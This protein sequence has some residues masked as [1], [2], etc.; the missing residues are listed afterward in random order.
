MFFFGTSQTRTNVFFL[1]WKA[2]SHISWKVPASELGREEIYE[3]KVKNTRLN[4]LDSILDSC[5][6]MSNLRQ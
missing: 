6:D 4:K 2:L 1:L 3:I 5:G